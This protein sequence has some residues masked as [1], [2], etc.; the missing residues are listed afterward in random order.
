MNRYVVAM[1]ISLISSFSFAGLAEGKSAF[2]R[3]DFN[4]AL[5]EFMPLASNNNTEAQIFLARMY[6][7][8][9]G[10]KKDESRG[11]YWYTKAVEH[12]N[13]EAHMFLSEMYKSGIGVQKDSV[14]ALEL[15]MKGIEIYKKAAD[16]GDLD[17]LVKSA[18]YEVDKEK[19]DR[20]YQEAALKG[21]SRAQY[22]VGMACRTKNDYKTAMEW[23]KKSAEGGDPNAQ[24]AIGYMYDNALGVEKNR[25]KAIEF[26]RKAALQGVGMSMKKAAELY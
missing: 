18:S 16:K 17:A 24:Y 12:G 10:V 4:T 13:P 22:I 7:S 20:I 11:V 9:R 5:E 8:G 3:E 26:F 6:N 19:K 23:F 1:S 25:A 14:K 21:N 15:K 2:I